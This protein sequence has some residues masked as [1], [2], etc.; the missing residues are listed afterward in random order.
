MGVGATPALG[1]TIVAATQTF[2]NCAGAGVVMS[3]HS[4]T[5]T[6][7]SV[8]SKRLSQGIL[9]AQALPTITS[10]RIPWNGNLPP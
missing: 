10:F 2:V 4:G 1:L 8:D 6:D 7:A 3:L 9:G 5:R